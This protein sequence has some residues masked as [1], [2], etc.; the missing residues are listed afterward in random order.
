MN[1]N[2]PT[3]EPLAFPL[4]THSHRGEDKVY[5]KGENKKMNMRKKFDQRGFGVVKY[6]RANGLNPSTL[7]RVLNGELNGKNSKGGA[8]SKIFEILKR[9][10]IMH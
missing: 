6:A 10:K 5:Q 3:L 1:T 9:D 2:N 4:P 8:V 7:S